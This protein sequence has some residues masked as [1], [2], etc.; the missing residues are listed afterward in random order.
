[1]KKIIL[2]TV[3]AS[4]FAA[5]VFAANGFA[6]SSMTAPTFQKNADGTN[7][8]DG[9]TSAHN[10]SMDTYV[11]NSVDGFHIDENGTVEM[12]RQAGINTN[13]HDKQIVN[14]ATQSELDTQA[15][16]VR[17]NS[18]IIKH[19]HKMRIA[20]D[21]ELT[22]SIAMTDTLL[23]TVALDVDAK[24]KA[25]AKVNTSHSNR[26]SHNSQRIDQNAEAIN[27]LDQ[28]VNQGFERLDGA[29][30][31][32]AA[33]SNLVRPYGVGN[34]AATAAIGGYNSQEALAIGVGARVTENTTVQGSI[35]TSLDNYE[36]VWGVGVGYEF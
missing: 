28:K 35:A 13:A 32:N 14:L 36:P 12:H 19:D 11:H 20:K 16:L 10:V 6:D 22:D 2:A 23:E 15:L 9:F 18:A 4:V 25:Q 5:P 31:A 24:A 3:I 8:A 34:V 30:A 29:V 33:M 26:I 17:S 27:F 1:M 21:K 7:Y